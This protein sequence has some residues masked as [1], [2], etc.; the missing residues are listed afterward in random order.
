MRTRLCG[1]GS[2]WSCLAYVLTELVVP[3]EVPVDSPM[4]PVVPPSIGMPPSL[5]WILSVP[6][7]LFRCTC[8]VVW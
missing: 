1:L 6:S 4:A 5:I 7:A 3:A 8:G 2:G